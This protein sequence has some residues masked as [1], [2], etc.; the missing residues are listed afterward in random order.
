[1]PCEEWCELIERYRSAVHSY[2][3]AVKV[4]GIS[5]ARHSLKR[6]SGLSGHVSSAVMRGRN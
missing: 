5:P 6:G 3:E 2:H 1:M 4:L